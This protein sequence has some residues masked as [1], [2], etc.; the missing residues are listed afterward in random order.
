MTRMHN[1]YPSKDNYE[2][3]CM[4]GIAHGDAAELII[5]SVRNWARGVLVWNLALDPDGGPYYLGA[6][7]GSICDAPLTID[8]TTGGVSYN[9]DFYQLGQASAFVHAGAHRIGTNSFVP[10]YG[11]GNPCGGKGGNSYGAG[12]VDNVAFKNHDGLEVLMA[13]NGALASETFAVSWHIHLGL[14]GHRWRAPR[15]HVNCLD[16]ALKDLP[17]PLHVM[18]DDLQLHGYAPTGFEFGQP[19]DFMLDLMSY[20]SGGRDG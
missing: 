13:Y 15:F 1:A 8:Q 10:R 20:M 11:N 19:P 4:T 6:G 3:E 5:A 7:C 14:P 12:T 2:T 16:D 18:N 17:T 9:R